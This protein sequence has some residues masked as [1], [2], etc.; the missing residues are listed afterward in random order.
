[1]QNTAEFVKKWLESHAPETYDMINDT[2][3]PSQKGGFADYRGLTDEYDKFF[4]YKTVSPEWNLIGGKKGMFEQTGF[5][6]SDP[7]LHSGLLQAIYEELYPKSL[8]EQRFM[9]RISKKTAPLSRIP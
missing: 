3:R 1:M 4:V 2:C 6:V 5:Q 7:D 9:R 8:T